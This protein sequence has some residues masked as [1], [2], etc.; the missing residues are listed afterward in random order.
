MTSA[1]KPT[2]AAM[3]IALALTLALG[4][5]ACTS[6]RPAPGQFDGSVAN[7]F[8]ALGVCQH[9]CTPDPGP[10]PMTPD[11]CAAAT[12]G[13]EFRNPALWTFDEPS[14]VSAVPP[15]AI[16]MYSYTDNTTSIENF[17][18]T[19]NPYCFPPYH[20]NP[21]CARKTWQ[22][23]TMQLARCG[24][25]T[26]HVIHIQGG[27]FL[28]WG[29]GIGIAMWHYNGNAGGSV[30]TV[31]S[32]VTDVSQ[33]EGISFWARRGPDSQAGVRVLAGDRNT[34]DDISYLMYRD[35]PTQPRY[36]ERVREC[37][38]LNHMACQDYD[39]KTQVATVYNGACTP[40]HPAPL[41]LGGTPATMSF[42]GPPF[43][44][45]SG[46]PG[47]ST[48]VSCNSCGRPNVPGSPPNP[49]NRCDEPYPAFD[50]DY[51]VPTGMT[52]SPQTMAQGDR[53]FL[54]K[55]CM[56]ATYR[57][58][59]TSLFCYDPSAGETVADTTEQCGDHWTMP[60]N[61]TN[62]W[63]F[64]T[65]PF[66][67]MTQ[68]GWAKKFPQLDVQHVSV[69]RF[70]WDGGWVDYYIDQVAFYRHRADPAVDAGP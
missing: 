20:S 41:A 53:Q 50:T 36:C 46:M 62:D 16:N 2:V 25:P 3:P 8:N 12:V 10:A 9:T 49:N 19:S 23:P 30:A 13:L 43:P 45:G 42:C 28:G 32:S 48:Y 1:A 54:H 15:D 4:L 29:G 11:D 44:L 5:V 26:N 51:P 55:P 27:P 64:Y 63:K 57:S 40:A 67:S 22:P 39:T 7:P 52:S 56:P 60:V 59:I 6:N 61:L 66:N 38:C 35:D 14:A 58:G 21:N 65:V 34:D 24:D 70:T 68:Q 69:V 33:W 47:A 37:A 18:D 31:D 17:V